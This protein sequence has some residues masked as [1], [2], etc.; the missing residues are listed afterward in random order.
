LARF[1]EANDVSASGRAIISYVGADRTVHH[2]KMTDKEKKM[3]FHE[4]LTSKKSLVTLLQL[5]VVPSGAPRGRTTLLNREPLLGDLRPA[6][7]RQKHGAGD[8][9]DHD[10]DDLL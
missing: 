3:P 5:E 4:F 8:D 2:Y 1:S 10:D 7:P 9:S 6:R